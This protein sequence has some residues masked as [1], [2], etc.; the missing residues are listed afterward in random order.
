MERRGVRLYSVEILLG[1]FFIVFRVIFGVAGVEGGEEGWKFWLGIC[2]VSGRID[3]GGSWGES[4]SLRFVDLVTGGT[5]VF[6]G[7]FYFYLRF[8]GIRIVGL[9]FSIEI[10]F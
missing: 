9:S 3:V 5:N 1:I 6:L 8:G 2:I 10:G 7:G 4:V